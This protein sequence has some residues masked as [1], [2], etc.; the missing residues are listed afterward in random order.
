M[1]LRTVHSHVPAQGLHE[2]V[3]EGP[4]EMEFSEAESG[5]TALVS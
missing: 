5:M 2:L 4:S 3:D 1:D